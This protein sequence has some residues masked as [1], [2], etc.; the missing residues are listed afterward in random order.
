MKNKKSDKLLYLAIAILIIAIVILLIIKSISKPI[1]EYVNVAGD[2][3]Y[4]STK[5]INSKLNIST[6]NYNYYLIGYKGKIENV[7]TIAGCAF[8]DN[9]NLITVLTTDG[10]YALYIGNSYI[11]KN[12]N[13]TL[14]L[15]KI[16]DRE[17]IK[18]ISYEVVGDEN[19]MKYD[20]LGCFRYPFVEYKDGSKKALSV[21]TTDAYKLL[22]NKEDYELIN[23]K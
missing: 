21:D 16:S 10:L 1:E 23:I 17:N 15:V 5:L 3:N 20:Y 7:I 14:K 2:S 6:T 8:D 4:V 9:Y 19:S 22:T 13:K 12:M 18:N 11:Y